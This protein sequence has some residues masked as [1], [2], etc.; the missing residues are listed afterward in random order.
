M[1]LNSM[2]V[3]N[4]IKKK[5]PPTVNCGGGVRDCLLL[6][7]SDKSIYT[8]ANIQKKHRGLHSRRW[9]KINLN[10][11]LTNYGASRLSKYTNNLLIAVKNNKPSGRIS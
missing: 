1:L 3:S 9:D 6:F 8:F 7:K 4:R 10:K 11:K 5:S 2:Y